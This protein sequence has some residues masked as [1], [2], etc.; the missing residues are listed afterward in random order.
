MQAVAEAKGDDEGDSPQDA[1]GKADEIAAVLGDTDGEET[2]LTAGDID[3]LRF[4]ETEA[5]RPEISES[6]ETVSSHKSPSLWSLTN[7]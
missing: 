2:I 7:L 4:A 5:A 3:L 1:S 6:M